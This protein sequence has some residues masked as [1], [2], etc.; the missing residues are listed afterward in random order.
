M[1]KAVI[2][3]LDGT[4]LDTLK[5]I[6]ISANYVLEQFG[7]NPIEIQKYRYLV[8]SG[9]LVLM[10]NILPEAS[11]QEHKNALDIFEKHYAKQFDLNTK[12]YENINKLLTFFQV[13]G[14]KMA[15]LSNKPNRFTKMCV[16][17]YLKHWNFESVYGIREGIPKKP[18]PQGVFEILK[19]L[20]VKP[21]ETLFVGDTK[22]DM[23][24]ARNAGLCPI[25]VLWGF[26]ERDEL[27]EHGAKFIVENPNE[28]VKLIVTMEG[29]TKK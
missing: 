18:D 9:A 10:Q 15:V 16:M 22:I 26:R 25:G 13:R 7:K 8:G 23:Q 21:E 17:K 2:F 6:A 28:L 27:L 19:E 24:T 29:L 5:D 14:Y 4:L 12:A 3:D 20:H 1:Y 11:E